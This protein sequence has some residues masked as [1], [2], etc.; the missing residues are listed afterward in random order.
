MSHLATWLTDLYPSCND[1]FTISDTTM[2]HGGLGSVAIALTMAFGNP[3]Q[4][5]AD[6]SSWFHQ[7]RVYRS[8]RHISL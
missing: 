7:L 8:L 5:T 2:S 3:V 1:L 4:W 6:H